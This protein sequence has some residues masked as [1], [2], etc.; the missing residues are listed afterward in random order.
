MNLLTSLKQSLSSLHK[1]SIY[2]YLI[3]VVSHLTYRRVHTSSHSAVIVNDR[4]EEQ[5]IDRFPVATFNFEHV[6]SAYSIT[7][8]IILGSL[9]KIGFH[10][11]HRLT[12]KF[13]ESCLLIILGLIVGALFY[14]TKVAG[15]EEYGLDSETFFIYLLPPIIL[16]AGYFMPNRSFNLKLLY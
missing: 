12:E 2:I 7:L 8:W 15:S 9:A 13:P 5:T 16:E 4:S 10:L 3:I 11:S 1:Y 6:S 14:S